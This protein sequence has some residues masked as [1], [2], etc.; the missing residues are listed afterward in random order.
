MGSRGFTIFY[1]YLYSVQEDRSSD[2]KRL[3]LLSNPYIGV[4]V[5]S[6]SLGKT[7]P[8]A[9]LRCICLHLV[10]SYSPANSH[11]FLVYR[12]DRIESP[13]YTIQIL[14]RQPYGCKVG[15]DIWGLPQ[16]IA[17]K[18]RLNPSGQEQLIPNNLVEWQP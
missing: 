14:D 7:P 13:R 5:G 10:S 18:M 4:K 11:S 8:V 2:N 17:T 16:T 1:F 12:L 9:V 15:W 6:S 3:N